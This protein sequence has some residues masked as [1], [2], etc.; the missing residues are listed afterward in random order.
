MMMVAYTNFVTLA[1]IYFYRVVFHV[2]IMTWNE[3]YNI[4]FCFLYARARARTYIESG[5]V[6][7]KSE[8]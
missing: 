7:L 6:W 3:D 1:Y 8:L 4:L 5:P 2:C